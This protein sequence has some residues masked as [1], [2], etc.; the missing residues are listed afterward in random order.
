MVTFD[1]SQETGFCISTDEKPTVGVGNGSIL[2]EIDTGKNFM[3]DA[4]NAL[5]IEQPSGGSGGGSGESNNFIVT[6]TE[7]YDDQGGT[8][9]ECDKTFDE[10]LTAWRSHKIIWCDY[11]SDYGSIPYLVTDVSEDT[12]G[13]AGSAGKIALSPTGSSTGGGPGTR[14]YV[15]NIEIIWFDYNYNISYMESITTDATG[16]IM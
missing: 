1:N 8:S 11:V 13:P 2:T 16:F 3:F 14:S 10:I 15:M 6:I 12:G 4:Q 5:W 9:R 7:T